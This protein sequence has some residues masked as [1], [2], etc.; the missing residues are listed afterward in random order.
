MIILIN[1]V[2]DY[3]ILFQLLLLLLFDVTLVIMLGL[4][5]Q[6]LVSVF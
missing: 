6:L 4:V 2:V 3:Q 1:E 5:T